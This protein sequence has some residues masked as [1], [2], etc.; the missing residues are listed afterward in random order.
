M[1]SMMNADMYTITSY[2][3]KGR[4]AS[5]V[6]RR[7]GVAGGHAEYEHVKTVKLSEKNTDAIEKMIEA[8]ITEE[9][10]MDEALEIGKARDTLFRLAPH[11][12]RE[13]AIFRTEML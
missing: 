5:V 7:R 4:R 13:G 9:K 10:D 2:V 1:S 12:L 6:L 8:A 11:L 3:G